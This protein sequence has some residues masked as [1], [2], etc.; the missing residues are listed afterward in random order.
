M[1]VQN[2]DLTLQSKIDRHATWML[3]LYYF[4]WVGA[5]GFIFPFLNLFYVREGLSGQQIGVVTAATSITMLIASPLWTRW[6]DQSRHPRRV[7]QLA[8][9]LT[10]LGWIWLGNQHIFGWILVVSAL[11]I[12]PASGIWPIS[13]DLALSIQG[14]S[15]AGYG[16]V[17]MWG[18]LG[19]AIM[20]LF[21]GWLIERFGLGI[22]FWGA[23]GGMTSAALVLFLLPVFKSTP[24]T[25]P[26]E[27]QRQGLPAVFNSLLRNPSLVGFAAMLVL[28]GIGNNGVVQFE[29]VYMD[30]LGAREALIGVAGMVSSVVEVPGM[31]WA[32]QLIRKHGPDR[33]LLISLLMQIFLRALVFI[34]P[35]V[36]AILITRLIN[37]I[38]FSFYTIA[39]VS[40]IT[41]RT[42]SNQRGTMLALFNV[43][44][45]GL[46]SILASP[47]SGA[48]YDAVGARVLYLLAIAGYL[49]GWLVLRATHHLPAKSQPETLQ[50]QTEN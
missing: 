33:I 47:L 50:T 44:L 7:L 35:T 34:W 15:R 36:P 4:T 48:I 38:A 46:I 10:G 43:T 32:D 30:A 9:I 40:Y 2:T 20:V 11:R 12:V 39:I 1:A 3:R 19:W 37:G 8:L 28:I 5:P 31:L 29:T 14:A 16:Q 18:S 45:A 17:R 25:A 27:K 13:D 42:P 41:N 6:S 24:Q 49:T 26:D 21:S 22:A 23:A